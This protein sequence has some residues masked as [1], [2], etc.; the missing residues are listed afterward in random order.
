LAQPAPK[1]IELRGAGASFPSKVYRLWAERYATL[2]GVRVVYAPTGSGDGIKQAQARKVEFGGTDSPLKPEQLAEQRLI[3]IPTLVGGLVPVVRLPGV[4]S[5][6]LLLNGPVL[7]DLMMGRI[8]RWN[9][10]RIAALNGDLALPA[11]P[12]RRIV[13]ADRSGSTE[14]FSK[15]LALTSEV[16]RNEVGASSLPAWPGQLRTA[17]GNDGV[18]SA[19]AETE[20]GITYV[21][22]DRVNA[23]GLAAVRLLNAEGS[24]VAAN[25]AGFR[26]AIRASELHRSGD[27][28]ASLLMQPGFGSWPITLTSFMLVDA[29]PGDAARAEA[30]LGFVFWCFM[31]GDSLTRGTGFAALPTSLQAR[32]AARLASVRD[33]TGRPLNFAKL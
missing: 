24:A 7:A 14:G 21:S 31:H 4:G 16:F 13:R 6:R 17:Q 29:R 27:D 19:L 8:E 12:V 32:V 20:G 9:D 33:A 22:F 3:Q 5:N 15:F 26:A 11:L 2:T 30:T 18:A 25:D 28:L 23:P 1:D 10:A